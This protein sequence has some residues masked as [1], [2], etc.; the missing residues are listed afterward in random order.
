MSAIIT[1][2]LSGVCHQIPE[3]CIT[4]TGGTL[5][6]CFRCTGL[7]LSLVITLVLLTIIEP[8]ART[9]PPRVSRIILALLVMFWV[10]DGINSTIYSIDSVRALYSPTNSLRI[11]SGAGMGFVLG[12]VLCPIL[13]NF[14]KGEA[15]DRPILSPWWHGPVA[16]SCSILASS[17]IFY[18]VPD[19]LIFWQIVT[20]WSV[21]GTI[22]LV[23]TLLVVAFSHTQSIRLSHIKSGLAGT[24]LAFLEMGLLAGIRA[25]MGV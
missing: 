16:L 18:R 4:L 14:W 21:I 6:L 9:W 13:L 22:S 10:L 12:I 17:M 2:F 25:N 23:N 5:F 11:Y 15:T 7:F 1:F 24:F 8:E 3:Q 19:S 20:G